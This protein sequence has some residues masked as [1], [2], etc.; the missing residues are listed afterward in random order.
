MDPSH[1]LQKSAGTRRLVYAASSHLAQGR[2]ENCLLVSRE[3]PG[4]L[5]RSVVMQL[6]P[7]AASPCKPPCRAKPNFHPLVGGY[8]CALF[9]AH[10][11]MPIVASLTGEIVEGY[12]NNRGTL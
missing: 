2:S 11:Q 6:S 4:L 9:P 5:D 12:L 10:E 1:E 8:A 3:H 7:G